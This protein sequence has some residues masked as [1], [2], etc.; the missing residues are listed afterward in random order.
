[1]QHRIGEAGEPGERRRPV[2]VAAQRHDAGRAQLARRGPARRQRQQRA[3]GRAAGGRRAGRRRR[4]RRSAERS[5]GGEAARRAIG[6]GLH[7]QAGKIAVQS[8]RR[9]PARSPHSMS[10]TVTVQPSGTQ[11]QRRA[12]RTDPPG[13]HPPGHRPALRLPGRRL[14]LVQVPHA[15]RPRDPRRAPAEGAQPRGGGRRPDPLLPGRAADRHRARGA[16]RAR[17]RRVPGPQ[18]AEPRDLDRQ[19][20]ARRR[21]PARCSCR[22][23][24]RSSTAPASTSSSS[25]ATAARRS[26][27][28][29]N[30]PHTPGRQAAA[31]SC[32]SATCPA[33][34]SPTTS[35][36]R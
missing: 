35:S 7:R 28:M 19:A 15:R 23:T 34:S 12:R 3:S 20:G 4:S 6:A 25:C 29:A 32:T 21:D 9:C 31:S 26:Y 2:E 30:A 16:H 14:R 36:A 13:R 33:A 22:P 11:L 24:T 10:F 8:R 18:D 27:S 5:G 17:R 1:M